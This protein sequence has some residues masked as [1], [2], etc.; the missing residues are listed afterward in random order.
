MRY[1]IGHSQ[2]VH[3]FEKG[4]PLVL[5]GLN[6]P[7]EYGLAG[8]SDAD[9]VF[10]AASEAIIGALG[11]GD[12]GTHFPDTDPK[13]K[14]I[15]SS[16]FV[17][18]AR[19][20]LSASGYKLSNLDLTVYAERPHLAP[21]IPMMRAR[22]AELLGIESGQVNIKATRGEGMGF[23][24]KGEGIGAECVVLIYKEEVVKKYL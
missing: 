23:I 14:D 3:R 2:D 4:R 1:R 13:Y 10:H 21:Y 24:G 22:L 17:L 8:H 6:I 11:L 15:A 12:L 5:G 19:K 18:E 20:M 9:C 16:F 7:F